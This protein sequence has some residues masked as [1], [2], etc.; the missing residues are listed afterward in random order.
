MVV[1]RSL[2]VR[3]PVVV[4]VRVRVRAVTVEVLVL[5]HGP[6]AAGDVPVVVRRPRRAQRG[7]GDGDRQRDEQDE[8]S[9]CDPTSIP[10]GVP[11]STHRVRRA[12]TRH[13]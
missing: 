4:V 13:A 9:R 12:P 8:R 3:G 5:V 11:D 2:V 1:A 10:G 7:G 6:C